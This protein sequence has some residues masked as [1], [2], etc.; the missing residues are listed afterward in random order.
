M[1]KT[2][3]SLLSPEQCGQLLSASQENT[4]VFRKSEGVWRRMG[5]RGNQVLSNYRFLKYWRMPA[6]LRA[7]IDDLVPNNLMENSNE[8]W[9]LHFPE[10]GQLDCF[11]ASKGLFNCL[12]IPLNSS[13]QFTL[14][15]DGKPQALTNT[16]GDAYLFSLDTEHEV[17][18][19]NQED[20]Y[21]CFLFLH[22]IEVIPNA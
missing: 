22:H 15:Q 3:S 19:T 17:P 21:L 14:W 9:L 5:A 20:W 6:S 1:S 7:L 16:A 11:K 2:I 8:I 18:T 10:G 13:G 4:D 12:S